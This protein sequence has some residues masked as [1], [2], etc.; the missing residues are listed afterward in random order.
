MGYNFNCLPQNSPKGFSQ[1]WKGTCRFILGPRLMEGLPSWHPKSLWLSP[2]QLMGEGEENGGRYFRSGVS[3]T[4]SHFLSFVKTQFHGYI[5]CKEGWEMRSSSM[6]GRKER[7]NFND[8]IE[9]SANTVKFY[10][11]NPC[12]ALCS[13]VCPKC[14]CLSNSSLS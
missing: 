14:I 3:H 4:A 7:V 2:F 12:L 5:N 8:I 11:T 9:E 13:S 1:W 10:C 6:P